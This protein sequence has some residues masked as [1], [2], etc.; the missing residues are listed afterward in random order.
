MYDHAQAEERTHREAGYVKEIAIRTALDRGYNVLA[1]GTLRN[2]K[3]Y[4]EYFL[5]LKKRY[6]NLRIAILYVTAPRDRG[7]MSFLRG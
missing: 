1:D 5:D 7:E 2:G 3:Y 6:T 4:E